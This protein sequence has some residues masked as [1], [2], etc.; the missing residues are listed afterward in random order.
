MKITTYFLLLALGGCS[1]QAP[2]PFMPTPL[3][4]ATMAPIIT[5]TA[6]PTNTPMPAATAAVAPTAAPVATT[7]IRAQNFDALVAHFTQSI[8]N[9]TTTGQ[10]YAVR[11]NIEDADFQLEQVAASSQQHG[12]FSQSLPVSNSRARLSLLNSA[13]ALRLQGNN[14]EA[15]R[16][17]MGDER[18]PQQRQHDEQNFADEVEA[19]W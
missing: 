11:G 19:R 12:D 13:I 5:P 6:T 16:L 9:A 15:R 1:S 2:A 3:P 14:T 7:D 18:S 17:L 4:V 8:L 10:L